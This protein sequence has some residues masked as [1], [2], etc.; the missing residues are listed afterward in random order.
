[1]RTLIVSLGHCSSLGRKIWFIE[2]LGDERE[3]IKAV[4]GTNKI[5]SAFWDS[6]PYE[7]VVTR[8]KELNPGAEIVR[9]DAEKK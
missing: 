3:K 5:P 1:M 2:E 7:E 4:F 8:L 9:A 6:M